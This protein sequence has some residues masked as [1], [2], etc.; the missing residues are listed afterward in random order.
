MTYNNDGP[1]YSVLNGKP[2]CAPCT[3]NDT[4]LNWTFQ[5]FPSQA[6]CEASGLLQNCC[7]CVYN[8]QL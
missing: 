3:E 5:G 6:A 2:P 7:E 4:E 1:I 8:G